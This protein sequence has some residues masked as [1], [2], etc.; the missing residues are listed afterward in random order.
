METNK[1]VKVGLVAGLALVM[2]ACASV[3]SVANKMVNNQEGG[4]IY[5]TGAIAD[6]NATEVCKLIQN[7]DARCLNVEKFE[8]VV[9]MS[10]FGYMDGAVGINAL[11]PKTFPN[12]DKLRHSM[13]T[14]DSKIPYVKAKVVPGQLGE[15]LEIV[16]T[17]G[18]GKCHW[19]GMP[20]I[21]GT[22]EGV[23]NFV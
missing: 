14:G 10:K 9:V 19:S 18:D 2:S 5:G 17:D 6:V 8:V 7:K 12:L 20:R 16:S 23:N 4:V 1:M 3:E 11:A 13:R 15:L 21:G 22:V